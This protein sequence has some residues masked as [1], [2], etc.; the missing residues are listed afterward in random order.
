[1]GKK[2]QL[3]HA[4]RERQLHLRCSA[5]TTSTQTGSRGVFFG[6]AAAAAHWVL[7]Q[8]TAHLKNG[9]REEE[10]GGGLVMVVV[11]S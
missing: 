8:N 9:E 2:G 5:H 1:M 6:P 7:F 4:R 10:E 3:D 11:H